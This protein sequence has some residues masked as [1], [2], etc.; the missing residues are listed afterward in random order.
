LT[1]GREYRKS[2][3]EDLQ[4]RYG[5]GVLW[6]H[7]KSE[8]GY[9]KTLAISQR[10]F[11]KREYSDYGVNLI[12]G[13]NYEIGNNPILGVEMLPQVTYRSGTLEEVRERDDQWSNDI[14]EKGDISGYNYGLSNSSALLVLVYRLN[15]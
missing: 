11:T 4:L 10:N 1:V 5:T 2:T 13:I 15:K 7:N 3:S 8:Q 6:T 12:L 14:D 9:N